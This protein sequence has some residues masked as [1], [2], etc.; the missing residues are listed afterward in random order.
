MCHPTAF[1]VLVLVQSALDNLFAGRGRRAAL[2]HLSDLRKMV[3]TSLPILHYQDPDAL[4]PTGEMLNFRLW[5]QCPRCAHVHRSFG[6][7][8]GHYGG[9]VTE[10]QC[11]GCSFPFRRA[12]AY[13][14]RTTV[15][16]PID[17]R[18][19]NVIS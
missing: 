1:D 10:M 19:S 6:R 18:A 2:R 14:I 12:V 5:I 17:W 9:E 11:D 4:L 16:R 7:D 3:R 13:G 15:R 8:I